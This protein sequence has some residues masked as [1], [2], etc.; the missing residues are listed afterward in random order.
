MFPLIAWAFASQKTELVLPLALCV[1]L[2]MGLA[3]LKRPQEPQEEDDAEF[4]RFPFRLVAKFPDF[5]KEIQVAAAV[6]A[7]I[8]MIFWSTFIDWNK[9][10]PAFTKIATVGVVASLLAWA[11]FSKHL[12]AH[13][14]KNLLFW[15]AWI[16]ASLALGWLVNPLLYFLPFIRLFFGDWQ[17]KNEE[18][19]NYHTPSH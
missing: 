5:W 3:S 19:N 10:T 1:A 12:E 6:L 14:H 7:I 17:K 4:L 11:S 13:K 9:W 16:V 15:V 2:F 8:A 18:I